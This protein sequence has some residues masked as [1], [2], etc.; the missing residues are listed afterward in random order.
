[1]IKVYY[2]NKSEEKIDKEIM[3]AMKRAIAYTV[4]THYPKHNFEVSLTL[5]GDEYIKELN[6]E[7]RNKP[8]STDV[9]SFPALSDIEEASDA[10]VI[11]IGSR[12][13]LVLGDI[14]LYEKVIERHA[15]EFGNTFEEETVYMVIHSVLHLLGYD[16]AEKEE[17]AVMTAK[18]E[19]LFASLKEK[20][21]FEGL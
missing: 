16:H 21:L 15:K 8:K 20:G 18:Q 13:Y 11:R 14:V 6:T 17:N 4:K 3:Y 7:Y 2:S 1:M 5:C 19:K 9:L 12:K 10:D